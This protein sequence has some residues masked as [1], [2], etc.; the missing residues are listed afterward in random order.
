MGPQLQYER[1]TRESNLASLTELMKTCFN[2]KVG[3]DYFKW[4][5]F[6]N[7]AG[8]IVAYSASSEGKIISYSGVIPE[9]YWENGKV[10]KIY[11]AVDTLTHPDFRRHGLFK[12]LANM[13]YADIAQSEKAYIILAF[14]VPVSYD[15]FV[16]KLGWEKV[17][18]WQFRFCYSFVFKAFS[19]FPEFKSTSLHFRS[20][21][22]IDSQ[23]TT[24]FSVRKSYFNLEKFFDAKTF[25]WK[26]LLN[27]HKKYEAL[28][29]YEANNLIG[30]AVF[31]LDSPKSCHLVWIDFIDQAHFNFASFKKTVHHLFALTKRRCIYTWSPTSNFQKRIF[32]RIGFLQNPFN[33]GPF[34][35]KM[36]FI[37]LNSNGNSETSLW[38]DESNYNFQ[39]IILD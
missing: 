6:D 15:G 26:V 32:N 7:P 16:N 28:G 14:P 27:K 20:I 36:P 38:K 23:I 33:K 3:Q 22:N 39:G 5:Y 9:L 35:E 12:K 17:F 19:L 37:V 29:I 31:H 24:Y 8:E 10:I 2:M 30:I 34:K 18:F 25:Q 13:C 21:Q 1:I 4:K 11:Q